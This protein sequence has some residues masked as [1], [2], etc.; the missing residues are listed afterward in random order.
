[1]SQK[2]PKNPL[3]GITLKQIV[4]ELVDHYG[5]EELG[6]RINIRSFNH[7]PS[8]KSSLKFLRRTPWARE[9]V[10]EL[11]LEMIAGLDE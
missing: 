2:Q 10:E 11:Y 3:H 5:W 4:T 7:D 8:L 1:M 6:A 9:K